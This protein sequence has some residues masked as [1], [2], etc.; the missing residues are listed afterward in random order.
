MYIYLHDCEL[1]AHIKS[2]EKMMAVWRF[3][4]IWVP[5]FIINLCLGIFHEI[6]HPAIGVSSLKPPHM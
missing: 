3:P 1:L 6:N 2:E 4:K 5:P